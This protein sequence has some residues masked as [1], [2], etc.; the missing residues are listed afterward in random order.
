MPDIRAV[1]FDMDGLLI[2]TESIWRK[3]EIEIFGRLGLRLTE[4]QCM[5]T[6]G[7]RV[8]EVVALWYRR[9]PWPGP[10]VAEVARQIVTGVIAHV[11]AEGGPMPGVIAALDT[12]SGAGL[13]MAIASSS[14]EDLIRAVLERLGVERYFQAIC[15]ANREAEGKPHPAVY[16]RA[17]QALGVP[18]E[19]CLALEDSPNGVLAAKAAGMFCVAVPDPHLA[20]DPRM[21]EADIRL[22]SLQAFTEG[23]LG[24]L[25][26]SERHSKEKAFGSSHR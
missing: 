24:E 11:K 10:P 7:T 8:A 1:I 2:D 25:V 15:S 14:S 18:P 9:H 22:D 3:V 21:N 26:T 23:L 6:M 16:L 17:A 13:P 19:C 5:E 4:Q 20:G 12:V